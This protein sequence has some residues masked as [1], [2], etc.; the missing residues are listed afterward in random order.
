[1]NKNVSQKSPEP[2]IKRA[3]EGLKALNIDVAPKK[4]EKIDVLKAYRE[5][6][7]KDSINF[8]VVGKVVILLHIKIV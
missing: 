5:S 4:V 1:M 7:A 3:E 2:A 6:K 8:V